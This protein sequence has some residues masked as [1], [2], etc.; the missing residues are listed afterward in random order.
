MTKPQHGT[1]CD[2]VRCNPAS[3]GDALPE[4]LS[5]EPTVGYNIK[6]PKSLKE[7]CLAAGPAR[8][9]EILEAHL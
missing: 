4:K 7:A 5:D 6:M 8:V 2:C 1:D 3:R 9:R